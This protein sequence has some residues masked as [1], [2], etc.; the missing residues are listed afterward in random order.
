VRTVSEWNHS[1]IAGTINVPVTEL[2]SALP[3]LTL[4]RKRRVVALC[5]SAHRSI[6]AVR[7]LKARGFEACQLQ[8]GM[9]AWGG[10]NPPVNGSTG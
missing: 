3:G 6:P 4:D 1:H 10:A 2:K 9:R 8:G 5:R 7:L